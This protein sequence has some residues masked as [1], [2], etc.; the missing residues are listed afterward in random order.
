MLRA[1]EAKGVLDTTHRVMQTTGQIFMYAIATGRAVRNPIPDL[2]GAIK[3]P[4]VK[5]HAYLQPKEI[6]EFLERLEAY[7]GVPLTK[8]AL[9]LL[10][11]TF[12]RTTELRAAQWSE[13]DFDKA[14]WRIPAERM[15][16][17]EQHIVPL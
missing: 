13:I 15:K 6:P 4:V 17:K 5:H 16:M 14:E 9:R 3:A 11:L 10:L 1:V 2:R 12:V 8:L 7:E